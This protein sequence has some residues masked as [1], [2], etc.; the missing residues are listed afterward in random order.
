MLYMG[1]GKILFEVKGI[2]M[3]RKFL[4]LLVEMLYKELYYKL[5]Q[6]VCL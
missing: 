3:N 6:I 5:R 4:Y 2:A 1:G